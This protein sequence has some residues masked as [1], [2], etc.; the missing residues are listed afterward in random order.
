MA[1]YPNGG[2]R[3]ESDWGNS[4]TDAE[5]IAAIRQTHLKANIADFERDE[6]WSI[7]WDR[8][9]VDPGGTIFGEGPYLKVPVTTWV[10][11]DD[12]VIRVYAPARLRRRLQQLLSHAAG[13]KKTK[14]HK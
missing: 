4:V 8:A 12:R 9:T 13:K 11:D 3:V 14:G 10:I 7:H 2:G 6:T 5:V 1:D